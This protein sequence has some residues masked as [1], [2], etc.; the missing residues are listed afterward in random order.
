LELPENPTSVTLRRRCV[1]WIPL[2][3]YVKVKPSYEFG[4]GLS[5]T[6]FD[7]SEIKLSSNTFS[8]KMDV[9]VIEKTRATTGK[10]VVQL[11]FLRLQK[12]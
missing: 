2:F 1:C 6:S 7:I 12:T 11:S 9:T 4:Y 5:Y 8:S 10:E 3:Q